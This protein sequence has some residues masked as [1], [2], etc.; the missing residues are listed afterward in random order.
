MSRKKRKRIANQAQPEQPQ[1]TRRKTLVALVDLKNVFTWIVIAALGGLGSLILWGYTTYC[2]RIEQRTKT[3]Q[4]I[5][6]RISIAEPQV[7]PDVN[8]AMKYLDGVDPRKCF[9]AEY[10]GVPLRKLLEDWQSAGGAVIDAETLRL[11]A[12]DASTSDDL[13]RLIGLL[14]ATFP[15]LAEESMQPSDAK[16]P[17]TNGVQD[18]PMPQDDAKPAAESQPTASPIEEPDPGN[19]DGA[20]SRHSLDLSFCKTLNQPQLGDDVLRFFEILGDLSATC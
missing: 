8:L 19:V 7:I 13:Q 16:P 10:V 5:R 6:N 1:Q 18:Q 20:A 2:A 17:A 11:A 3:S 14:K 12:K 15:D 4:E 9:H